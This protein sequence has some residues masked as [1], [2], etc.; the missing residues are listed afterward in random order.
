MA[1][2]NKTYAKAQGVA[3]SP[4]TSV[5][6]KTAVN[7]E[8]VASFARDGK[9]DLFLLAVTNM[10]GEDT[11]Y[12]SAAV[13]DARFKSLVHQV[14]GED[15]DWVARFIPWLR[16]VANMRTASVVAAVEYV[17]AGGP[18]ARQVINSAISRADEPM[19][20]LSYWIGVY[21][22][23][24]P[25]SVK[26]GV[27]DALARV[28]NEYSV[29]KYDGSGNSFRMGDV[30]NLTRPKGGETFRSPL[31]KYVQDTR[32][33]ATPDV[34]QL[35]MLAKRRAVNAGE[36]TRDQLL[37]N[38]E[39]IKD[40]GMTWE[41]LSGL[42]AMDAAAW[43][44]VIPNMGYMALLRNLRNFEQAG[45]SAASTK[46]VHD[47]LTDPGQVA[48]SR[49]FPYRFWSAYKNTNGL[50]YASAIETALDLSLQNLPSFTGRTLIL[51]D[52]SGSMRGTMSGK[53]T[54]SRLDAAALFAMA[55]AL[56][57]EDV[58]LYG[59][60]DFSYK[61]EIAKGGSVLREMEKFTATCGKAGH[62]TNLAQAMT[63][64]SGHDRVVVFSDMQVTSRYNRGSHLPDSVPVYCFNLAGYAKTQMG[65]ARD[66][67][68]G[69]L[70]DATFKLIPL[71]EQR[72]RGEWPF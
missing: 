38:P 11:Y 28:W 51:T 22:R 60:A 24:I 58:D 3:S 47:F 39:L 37:A 34:S 27:N 8:G 26:R 2:L 63:N 6:T 66:Y 57:G 69:G 21:G 19:E 18:N 10:V 29:A 53:S 43:E 4:I 9:S 20:L 15:A 32:F 59:W 65:E 44:A 68:L 56:K 62:G 23:P 33:G 30:V 52:T 16:N 49:Q 12:E 5:G 14:T 35:P 72:R 13:R 17:R 48:R 45:I 46:Y 25:S 42:G 40:A 50:K 67:E 71:I 55:L 64:Y 36:I 1:K 54:M 31:Y 70:T 61:H 41:S 7:H